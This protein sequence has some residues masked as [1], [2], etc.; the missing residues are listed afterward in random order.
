MAEGFVFSA[1][2]QSR[3]TDDG[4]FVTMLYSSLLNRGADPE[5]YATWTQHLRRGES[6]H[7]VFENF[8][9]SAEFQGLCA[10]YGIRAY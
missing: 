3:G 9:R 5:G 4:A 6:R 2:Y 10:A 7:W 8:C 1:E